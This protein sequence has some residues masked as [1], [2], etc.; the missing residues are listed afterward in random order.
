MKLLPKS[1]KQ[2]DGAINRR[3][4]MTSPYPIVNDM[5]ASDGIDAL[6]HNME[7]EMWSDEQLQDA[8]DHGMTEG[9]YV[10]AVW[11][12]A[13]NHIGSELTRVLQRRIDALPD[14][15]RRQLRH[16]SE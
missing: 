10:E 14:S 3:A 4:T 12:D 8:M 13:W 9:H 2:S 15:D 5:L 16:A 6:L 7:I 11:S 1:H